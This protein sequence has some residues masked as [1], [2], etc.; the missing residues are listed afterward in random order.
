MKDTECHDRETASAY[1]THIDEGIR[2]AK[3]EVEQEHLSTS[4]LKKELFSYAPELRGRMQSSIALACFG[5]MFGF[6]V[7]IFAAY[8]AKTL[9]SG[10]HTSRVYL[11]ALGALACV[12]FQKILT[13]FSTT[14]SHFIA[15]TILARIREALTRKLERMPLGDVRETPVGAMKQLIVERVGTM[16]D[17][18][19]HVMP[20]L[21]SRMLHPVL[22]TVFLF[23]VDWRVGLAAFVTL[24]LAGLGY[25]LMMRG[26]KEKMHRWMVSGRE[27]NAA[28]IEYVSG[29]RV[30][31]AFGRGTMAFSKFQQAVEYY[32][33]STMQWWRQSWLGMAFVYAAMASPI[34]GTLP[35]AARLYSQG[36]ID[37]FRLMLSITL[38]MAILPN[39][40]PIAMSA[41]LFVMVRTSWLAIRKELQ[42]PELVR[43]QNPVD[44]PKDASFSFS[45]VSF[46]Y[47]GKTRALDDVSFTVPSGQVTALVGPS[48]SG[49]STIAKLM[50]GFWLPNRG[51]ITYGSVDCKCIPEAQLMEE[52]AYVSQDM[53]LFDA[54]IRENLRI[55]KPDA[56]DEEMRAALQA[57]HCLDVVEKLPGGL[58]ASVG[59]C[60]GLLSG[61]ERQR[62]TLARAMLKPSKLM[63]LDEATAYADPENEAKIQE[64]IAK[65]IS[66]KTLVVIAH[67]LHTVRNADQIL[68]VERGRIVAQGTH[69]S[70]MKS[71]EL[72]RRLAVLDGSAEEE[73]VSAC[74][75]HAD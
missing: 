49:K 52:I 15:F 38:P 28:V 41:E 32:Y 63:I 50:A 45:G 3:E 68:V 6:A 59:D 10:E 44:L 25:I 11:T 43:A 30:I 75:M 29:I 16:E 13:W 54:T 42:K 66:G 48:G 31:K 23:A 65:L 20:E 69:A 51:V 62:L 55:A 36:E 53:F 72:Y 1:E 26:Y 35:V 73:E 8:A 67:R 34:L 17:W 14:R 39:A 46:S 27:M 33:T 7:F 37:L 5:E 70:L 18:I 57:A 22:A 2:V 64:A 47:D 74:A 60:G 21:P 71:S 58:D 9:I 4:V 12:A 19:A 61:G 24:P 56:S 40:M